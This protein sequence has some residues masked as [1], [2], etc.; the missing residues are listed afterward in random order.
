MRE[1]YDCPDPAFVDAERPEWVLFSTDSCDLD[2]ETWIAGVDAIDHYQCLVSGWLV[3]CR[4][5]E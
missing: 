4:L 3:S 2:F 1:T 5:M